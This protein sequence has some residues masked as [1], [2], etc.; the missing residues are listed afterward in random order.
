MSQNAQFP[1]LPTEILGIILGLCTPRQ[2]LDIRRIC[3][4]VNSVAE[5]LIFST[6]AIYSSGLLEL[7]ADLV[8][9]LAEG[10]TKASLYAR[11]LI[12][13]P[14][15]TFYLQF[16]IEEHPLTPQIQEYLAPA[17][18]SLKNVRSVRWVSQEAEPDWFIDAVSRFIFQGQGLDELEIE[19]TWVTLP[20]LLSLPNLR[21][22]SMTMMQHNL[23][24]FSAIITNS[25][26]LTFLSIDS[27]WCS[28]SPISLNEIFDNFAEPRRLL[29][30]NLRGAILDLSDNALQ[31]LRSL[32]TLR[33]NGQWYKEPTDLGENEDEDR[34]IEEGDHSRDPA[35]VRVDRIKQIRPKST[36]FWSTLQRESIRLDELHVDQVDHAVCDYIASYTGLRELHLPKVDGTRRALVDHLADYFYTH[37]LPKHITTLERLCLVSSY[38]STWALGPNNSSLF[39]Q[40]KNLRYLQIGWSAE[41]LDAKK[42]LY[43]ILD[44]SATLPLLNELTISYSFR[45]S[46]RRSRRLMNWSWIYDK[47]AHSALPKYGPIDS[48]KHLHRIQVHKLKWELV[49]CGDTWRYRHNDLSTTAL[50]ISPPSTDHSDL[51]GDN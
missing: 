39:L 10:E 5:P 18:A 22:L 51:V 19:R 3:R 24:S 13:E 12:V 30:L 38:A 7:T 20:P 16:D 47:L 41:D 46:V 28:N 6:V 35:P 40:C 42:K 1:G 26:N 29:H 21:S 32:R 14:K 44:L 8:K 48:Q 45:R 23:Q 49:Q 43:G 4:R 33:L 25:P 31:H 2:L 37:A 27:F 15:E 36:A 9:S 50:P 11:R 34:E 17:L